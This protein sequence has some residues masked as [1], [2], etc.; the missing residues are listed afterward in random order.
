MRTFE[1]TISDI[2]NDGKPVENIGQFDT[3]TLQ[4]LNKAVKTGM[5]A[6]GKGGEFPMIKTVYAPVGFD[7]TAHRK[8]VIA[9]ENALTAGKIT[10]DE[11]V[12]KN[13]DYSQFIKK[14]TNGSARNNKVG[15]RK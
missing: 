10:P 13:F 6:K 11:Y 2:V 5:I 12:F 15:S 8:A 3:K 7:F 1:D 9:K 14:R 4:L